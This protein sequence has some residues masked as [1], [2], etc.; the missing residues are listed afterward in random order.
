MFIKPK[1]PRPV[2]CEFQNGLYP[3]TKWGRLG[4]NSIAHIFPKPQFETSKHSEM[5][6]LLPVTVGNRELRIRHSKDAALAMHNSG[7]LSRS[8]P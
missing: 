2:L 6:S 5:C 4:T 7:L 1:S 8:A 3:S